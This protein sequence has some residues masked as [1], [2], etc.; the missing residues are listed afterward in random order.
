METKA[1]FINLLELPGESFPN[2]QLAEVITDNDLYGV[3]VI[4]K[5]NC[6]FN[7]RTGD[8][9]MITSDLLQTKIKI[10]S[11]EK[12]VSLNAFIEAYRHGKEVKIVIGD[13]YR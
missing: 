9:L 2:G 13:N 6:L 5:D 1:K 12:E 11:E 7:H 8:P 10:V 4:K 3:T